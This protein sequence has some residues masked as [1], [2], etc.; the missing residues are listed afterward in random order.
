[1]LQTWD[2]SINYVEQIGTRIGKLY[3][4]EIESWPA[5]SPSTQALHSKVGR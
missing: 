4:A 5:L 3:Q 2:G 1:M